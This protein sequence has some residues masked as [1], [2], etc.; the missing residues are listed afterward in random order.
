MAIACLAPSADFILRCAIPFVPSKTPSRPPETTTLPANPRPTPLHSRTRIAHSD[1]TSRQSRLISSLVNE[2]VIFCVYGTMSDTSIPGGRIRS[3][4]ERIEHL[5][6]E[7]QELN[8]SEKGSL[9]R[10]EG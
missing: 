10:G 9:C 8:E 2:L 5:D 3:F 1:P 6:T 7:L 4:V